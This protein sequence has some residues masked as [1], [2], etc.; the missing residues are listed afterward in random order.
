MTNNFSKKNILKAEI[1]KK[2]KE[3][4]PNLDY[5]HKILLKFEE[6]DEFDF[7]IKMPDYFDKIDSIK[8]VK[9]LCFS[10]IFGLL[11]SSNIYWELAKFNN[12]KNYKIIVPA[13][14]EVL[15][16]F[17]SQNIKINYFISIYLFFKLKIK[18]FIKSI[19]FISNYLS[20]KKN[21]ELFSSPYIFVFDINKDAI[22][23]SPEELSYLN[24]IKKYLSYGKKIIQNKYNKNDSNLNIFF[25]KFTFPKISKYKIIKLYFSFFLNTISYF[26][27]LFNPK[28]FSVFFFKE[29][30]ESKII[31]LTSRENLADMYIFNNVARNYRPMWTYNPL[32]INKIFYIFYG[33]NEFPIF[34]KDDDRPL[35][36]VGWS[37]MNWPIYLNWN[38]SFLNFLN[39]S[40]T[41]KSKYLHFDEP[42]WYRDSKDNSKVK[43]SNNKKTIAVYDVTPA[44]T[45]SHYAWTKRALYINDPKNVIKFYEDILFLQDKYN[46]NLI[47]KFKKNDRD[48]DDEIYKKIFSRL[49]LDSNN[50]IL[51]HSNK[52]PIKVNE[53]ANAIISYPFTSAAY[54]NSRNLP[55]IYYDPI[56]LINHN[57]QINFGVSLIGNLNKLEEWIKK[58]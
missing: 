48:K 2:Y 36:N 28:S 47:I 33:L 21:E 50:I 1:Y 44:N 15:K 42:I 23:K 31:D 11:S 25:S 30:F 56:G 29:F 16:F 45:L 55:S 51:I 4:Y 27:S 49:D 37:L 35:P 18:F 8:L 20:M 5:S 3:K 14:I 13:S 38:K 41:V 46:F 52:S 17:E 24:W 40:L 43:F 54:F 34:F 12:L 7:K 58:V 39:Q 32:I 57:K 6:Y 22:P 26:F 19:I 9:Q 53:N 10:Q